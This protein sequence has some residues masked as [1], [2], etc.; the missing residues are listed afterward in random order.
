MVSVIVFLFMIVINDRPLHQLDLKNG[1]VVR[2]LTKVI[3]LE[4]IYTGVAQGESRLVSKFHKSLYNLKQSL[5]CWFWVV[6]LGLTKICNTSQSRGS[7]GIRKYSSNFCI[8]LLVYVEDTRITEG[9]HTRIQQLKE[10]LFHHFE[11]RD[12][13]AMDPNVNL[14]PN[15]G[16]LLPDPHT[17]QRLVGRSI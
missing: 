7:L 13:G 4:Q 6:Q 14:F 10:H 11:T 8:Y 17:S 15:Q 12:S 2:H 9:D 5:K 1:F 16:K 3:Y